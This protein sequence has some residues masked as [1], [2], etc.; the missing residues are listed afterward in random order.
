MRLS[1]ATSCPVLLG[2]TALALS[3]AETIAQPPP[4]CQP[5]RE[6]E[7]LLL[8]RNQR[9]DTQSQLQQLLPE[10]AVL[11]PCNYL[12]TNVVRVEGF[13]SAD[14]ATAW[15][16]YLAETADLQAYVTR[17]A[18]T[19]AVATAPSAVG[20]TSSPSPTPATATSAAN[21]DTAPANDAN[22]AA[23]PGF[24]PQPLG[25][26]YAVLVNYFNRPEV[27]AEVKQVTAQNVGLVAFEQRPFLLAVHTADPAAASAVLKALSERG[28]TA[29]IVDS[30]RAILLAPTVAES[31]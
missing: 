9:P 19:P 3:S 11:T 31:N 5:P 27:A 22:R 6:N 10:A 26:G 13:A 23:A 30:R 15:A 17:L 2:A 16:Q 7:Y 28:L 1:L 4:N 24:N 21:P 20:G 29:A 12:G 14:I 18:E 25:A 8:V